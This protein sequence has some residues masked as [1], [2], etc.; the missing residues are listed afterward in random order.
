MTF[1]WNTDAVF[2]YSGDTLDYYVTTGEDLVTSGS[3]R[4]SP[5]DEYIRINLREIAEDWLWMEFRDFLPM[6]GEEYR[7]EDAFRTFKLY[8]SDNNLLQEFNCVISELPIDS[9]VWNAPVNGH[10]D[11]R[12]KL[13]VGYFGNWTGDTEEDVEYGVTGGFVVTDVPRVPWTG[14]VHCIGYATDI[15]YTDI[16]VI[17]PAGLSI[18]NKDED[19]VC[20]RFPENNTESGVTWTVCFEYSGQTLQ[21][22]DVLQDEWTYDGDYLTLVCGDANDIVVYTANAFSYKVGNNAWTDVSAGSQEVDIQGGDVI[23]FKGYSGITE[24]TCYERNGQRTGTKP[25]RVFGNVMSI[26]WGDDFAGKRDFPNGNKRLPMFSGGLTDAGD[27]IIPLEEI[28]TVGTSSG[29]C[30]YMFRN[31]TYLTKTP[32]LRARKIGDYGCK[33]MYR[34]CTSLT[35]AHDMVAEIYGKEACKDMYRDCTA[36]IK[37]P[38]FQ[39]KKITGRDAFYYAFSGCTALTEAAEFPN[40]IEVRDSGAFQSMYEECRAL[41]TAHGFRLSQK[42]STAGYTFAG[43]Y[44]NCTQ[45][46]SGVSFELYNVC[47]MDFSSTLKR[48]SGGA[49]LQ[50]F[51][52]K[53]TVVTSQQNMCFGMYSEGEWLQNRYSGTIYSTQAVK[54]QMVLENAIPA[55]WSVQVV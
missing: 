46:Y 42:P 29:V 18:V 48:T 27:L 2:S 32:T 9:G 31:C 21:C 6:D 30:Q 53:A 40:E 33:E 54:D 13:F 41:R 39:T 38:V 23:R 50:P 11:C 19:E 15:P 37:G 20:I 34:N 5:A 35:E 43:T 49:E 12:Q 52:L 7:H 17:L 10:A 45:L 16:D 24:F 4:R 36:L 51:T 14:G 26:F 25:Y 22:V 3:V 47:D 28:G 55:G 1:N 8:D 44:Y